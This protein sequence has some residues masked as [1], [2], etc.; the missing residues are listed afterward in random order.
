[1]PTVGTWSLGG[2]AMGD[3]GRWG[4]QI[5]AGLG[6]IGC[7]R[8]EAADQVCLG[9]QTAAPKKASGGLGKRSRHKAL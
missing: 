6:Q 9:V 8:E 7:F 5:A 4:W 3:R 2:A 1:M